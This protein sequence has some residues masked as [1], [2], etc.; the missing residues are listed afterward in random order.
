M[1]LV[2][3]FLLIWL[4]YCAVGMT[5]DNYFGI[6]DPKAYAAVFYAL[7]VAMTLIRPVIMDGE[8]EKKS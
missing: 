3:Y 5:M 2:Q 6:T 7:G 8:S 1:R 4:A